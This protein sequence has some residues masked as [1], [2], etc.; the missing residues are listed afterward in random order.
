MA[1]VPHK[2]GNLAIGNCL[3]SDEVGDC[4]RVTGDQV[5]GRVQVTSMDPTNPTEDQAIGIII[6][7]INATT[8]MVIFQGTMRDVYTG[9]VPGKRY[10]VGSDAKLTDVLPSPAPAGGVYHLQLM[11]VAMDD[12]ELLLNPQ[13]P[14]MLRGT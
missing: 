10:W 5:G 1:V 14:T 4:V 9:L 2:R 12:E 8:C 3:A 7:K 13:M 11:G 6:D